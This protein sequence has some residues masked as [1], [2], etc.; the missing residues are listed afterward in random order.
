MDMPTRKGPP[1][2]SG[3]KD[4]VREAIANVTRGLDRYDL[5]QLRARMAPAEEPD[6][7]E[8]PPVPKEECPEC[9][10]G[11]CSEPEHLS[12]EEM[13]LMLEGAER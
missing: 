4:P 13:R 11:T 6:E 12:E 7:G 5:D 1:G 10:T 3:G 8:A 9:A 2:K